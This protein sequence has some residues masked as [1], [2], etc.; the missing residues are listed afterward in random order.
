MDVSGLAR[1]LLP[2]LLVAYVVVLMVWPVMRLRRQTGAWA[3]TLHRETAP[4]QRVVALAFLGVQLGVVVLVAVF[5]L[6]GPGALGVWTVPPG[7]VWLGLLLAV[8]GLALVAMAQHQMGASFRIGIDDTQ[9][10]LVERGL[11]LAVRNPIFTG[12]LLL[13]AGVVLAMPCLWSVLAWVT[14]ALA[15]ARQTRLEERHL[16]AMHG[17]SYRGYAARVGRFLP[18][19]GRLRADVAEDPR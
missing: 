13:L 4:G 18:G 1:R 19:I 10:P 7:V 3:V 11:F 5:T 17:A 14:A 8:L 9:T 2:F 16:L 6:R 15:V 12:V